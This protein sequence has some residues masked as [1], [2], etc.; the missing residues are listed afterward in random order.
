MKRVIVNPD[1]PSDVEHRYR[2]ALQVAIREAGE[3]SILARSCTL[4]WDHPLQAGQMHADLSVRLFIDPFN[5]ERRYALVLEGPQTLI[6]DY[7]AKRHAI[8]CYEGVVK[9]VELDPD[10]RH[11]GRTHAWD[12]TDVSGV[13]ANRM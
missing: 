9:E 10:A 7:S 12:Y 11:A 4:D 5:G 6:V 3:S 1:K 2:L 13:P 8:K